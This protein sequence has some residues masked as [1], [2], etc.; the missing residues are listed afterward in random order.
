MLLENY[1]FSIYKVS[2][3]EKTKKLV[4]DNRLILQF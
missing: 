1:I 2:I 3:I 4:I